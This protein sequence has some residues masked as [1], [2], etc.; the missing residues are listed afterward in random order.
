MLAAGALMESHI[1]E[2]YDIGIDS[3]ISRRLDKKLPV[4]KE[5]IIHRKK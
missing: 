3:A 2:L 1:W 4:V 5:R